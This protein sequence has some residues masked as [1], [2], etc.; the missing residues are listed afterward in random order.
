MKSQ[1]RV[2]SLHDT[3]ET[4]NTTIRLGEDEDYGTITFKKG[5]EPKER[6]EAL[7]FEKLFW[8]DKNVKK[9]N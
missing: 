6:P 3:G 2:T 8:E 4:V 1:F 5:F 9:T 7:L